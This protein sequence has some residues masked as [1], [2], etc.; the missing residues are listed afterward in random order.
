MDTAKLMRDQHGAALWRAIAL[1]RLYNYR[2]ALEHAKIR[3]DDLAGLIQP[4][5]SIELSDAYTKL[6]EEYAVEPIHTAN[7]ARCML[8]LLAAIHQDR[9]FL[10]I[11]DEG[12]IASVDRDVIDSI[13]LIETLSRWVNKLDIAEVIAREREARS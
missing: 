6:M 2:A 13:Q 11:F 8:D 9:Q 3:G 1:R 7:A 10:Y 4:P 5:G 12:P